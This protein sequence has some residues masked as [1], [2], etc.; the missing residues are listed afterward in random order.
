MNINNVQRPTNNKDSTN[1]VITGKFTIKLKN[2]KKNF[3]CE[4][5]GEKTS[6][7]QSLS[8]HKLKNCPFRKITNNNSSDNVVNNNYQ[9]G[10]NNHHSSSNDLISSSNDD[11][12]SSSY[13]D[14]ISSNHNDLISSSH[15]NLTYEETNIELELNRKENVYLKNKLQSKIPLYKYLTNQ[16]IIYTTPQKDNSPDFG[17]GYLYLLR[18]K[19]YVIDCKTYYKIG[20]TECSDPCMYTKRRGD[21][22]GYELILLVKIKYVR[23]TEGN[24]K[25]IFNKKFGLPVEGKETFNGNQIEMHGIINAYISYHDLMA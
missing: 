12:I 17:V 19:I 16:E 24:L 7:R 23:S 22:D 20:R 8:R 4:K 25:K 2:P 14:F 18:K 9:T 10:M 5:C 3:I 21:G 1:K 15:N 13:N 11:L 6:F